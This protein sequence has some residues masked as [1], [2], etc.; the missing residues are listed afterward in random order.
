MVRKDTKT[1]VYQFRS[2][3]VSASPLSL[4]I[5]SLDDLPFDTM[6]ILSVT[7]PKDEFPSAHPYQP[8]VKT[9]T[10]VVGDAKDIRPL[11]IRRRTMSAPYPE[12]PPS[13]LSPTLLAVSLNAAPPAMPARS[14]LRN[15]E[16]SG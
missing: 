12:R 9:P 14:P 10:N 15:I 1:Q 7:I 2:G 5:R 8:P 4:Q 3:Q 6:S 11:R 13:M 16:R